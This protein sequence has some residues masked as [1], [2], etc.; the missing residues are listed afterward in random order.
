M[1]GIGYT[2]SINFYNFF[3]KKPLYECTTCIHGVFQRV[4]LQRILPPL[5]KECINPEMIPFVLP[6]ILQIAEQASDKEYTTLILPELIPMF[7][8]TSPVQVFTCFGLGFMSH[9]HCQCCMATVKLY[10]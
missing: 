5:V 10:W 6:N 7:K 3:S 4:N 9:K 8:I 2:D 1:C